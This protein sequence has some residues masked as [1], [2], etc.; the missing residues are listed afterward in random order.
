MQWFKCGLLLTVEDGASLVCVK[1]LYF[2]HGTV[3][4]HFSLF[5]L[6]TNFC[7]RLC[8]LKGTVAQ[9]LFGAFWQLIFQRLLLFF[10]SVHLVQ[11]AIELTVFR[12]HIRFIRIRVQ[13][14]FSMRIQFQ[15]ANRM[16]IHVDP[17]LGSSPPFSKVLV[18]SSLNTVYR[19]F[20]LSFCS[21]G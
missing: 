19:H 7:Y 2:L 9:D 15:V 21:T 6:N 5:Y 13:P 14:E 17:N 10:V 4:L 11:K 20:L 18:I 1:F 16:G 12:I 3:H 8:P